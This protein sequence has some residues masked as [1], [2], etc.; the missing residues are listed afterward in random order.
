MVGNI[1][2]TVVAVR[3]ITAPEGGSSIIFKM[4]FWA[5]RFIKCASSTIATRRPPF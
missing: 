2:P 5:L 3:T 4:A 1:I